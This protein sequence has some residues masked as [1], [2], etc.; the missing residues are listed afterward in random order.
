MKYEL[1]IILGSVTAIKMKVMQRKMLIM[2]GMY[3]P[4]QLKKVAICSLLLTSMPV[5]WLNIFLLFVVLMVLFIYI[6]V[7]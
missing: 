2:S 3:L 7:L 4:K 5:L 1:V 6:M